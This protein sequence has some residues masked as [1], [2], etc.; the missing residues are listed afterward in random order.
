MGIYYKYYDFQF[1]ASESER[2]CIIYAHGG[3][4]VSGRASQYAN[5]LS[6]MALDCGVVVFNVDY[7]LAPEYRFGIDKTP[8][9]DFLT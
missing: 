5:Y 9:L 4:C 1:L 2:P 6:Y 8:T 7:R 3:G